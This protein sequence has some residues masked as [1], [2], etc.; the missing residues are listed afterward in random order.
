MTL[1]NFLIFVIV[2]AV[3]AYLCYWIITKFF[4]APAQMPA[5]A[6]VGIL[7]LLV[8]LAQFFP[9]AAGVRLWR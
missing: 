4:P 6:I 3:I 8:V 1:I 5:L 7:L 9:E 2:V